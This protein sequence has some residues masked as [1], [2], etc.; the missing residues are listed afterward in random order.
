MNEPRL[1]EAQQLASIQAQLLRPSRAI[2]LDGSFELGWGMSLLCFG[3]IPYLNTALHNVSYGSWA[4]WVVFLFAAFAP[5][6][7]PKMIK[8]FVTWPRTGY[9]ALPNEMKL[10]QLIKLMIFGAAL[11]FA[12]SLPL[13]IASEIRDASR[14]A[15]TERS[16]GKIILHLIE[17]L[18]CA[19][20]AIYLGR[21]TIGKRAPLPSAFT[22]ALMTQ[23]PSYIANG[24]T[25]LWTVRVVVAG[26]FIGIPLIVGG[27]VAG[28]AYMS[29]ALGRSPLR[30]P[31]WTFICLVVATNAVLY[32]MAN[33]AVLKQHRWKW[34]CFAMLVVGPILL[35]PVIPHPAPTP[36]LA[37]LF[38]GFPPIAVLLGAVWVFSGLVAL[39]W[40]IRHNPA[41]S[42]E[43]V[44]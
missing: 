27:V 4:S 43:A 20:A 3:S 15:P 10:I 18:V 23:E 13:I 38:R 35:A 17:F 21:T 19:A 29:S 16:L 31:E 36:G 12:I 24:R 42:L 7:I 22:G 6:A 5:Y 8:R 32:L 40:F 2:N 28:L 39:G 41:R 25:I 11:G 1:P 44:A 34:A 14:L 9:A 37:P 26:I 33:G 30:W